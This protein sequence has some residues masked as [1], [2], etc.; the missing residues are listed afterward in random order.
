[1]PSNISAAPTMS[2]RDLVADF[3]DAM[4][5][6]GLVTADDINPDGTLHRFH[7]KGDRKGTKNGWYTL[8]SDSPPSGAFGCFKRDI[9]HTWTQKTARPLT[10]AERRTLAERSEAARRSRA[11]Q[12]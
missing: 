4:D 3:K 2:N 9:V 8:H 11:A 6:A 1:M 10:E 5:A 7:V 12:R